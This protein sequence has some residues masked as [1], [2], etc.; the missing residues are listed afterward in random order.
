MKWVI[1]I[2]AAIITFAI[3]TGYMGGAKEA[4]GNYG[5][6]MRGG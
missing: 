5:K 2:F 3:V 1:I 6:V 4:A